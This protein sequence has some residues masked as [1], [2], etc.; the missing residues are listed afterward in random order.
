MNVMMLALV[1]AMLAQ[2]IDRTSW[3][4]AMLATHLDR[5]GE[6]II[7]TVAA[8]AL[9]NAAAA[10]AGVALAPLLP[11][12]SRGVL[13]AFALGSAGV[14]ALLPIKP[15]RRPDAIGTAIGT[16]IGIGAVATAFA[17]T[18][19]LQVGDATQFITLALV[20]D[21]AGGGPVGP[22]LAAIG[23]VAGGSVVIVAAAL[24]GEAGRASL[25]VRQLRAAIG[26]VF[27]VAGAVAMVAAFRLI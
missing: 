25:P 16:G 6:I 27:L 10:A 21:E 1:A 15:P 4:T 14:S 23:A 2:A 24:T 26:I 7:G 5:P 20:A 8:L 17:G 12:L 22:A 3:R 18:A 19:M 11:D 13:L 9:G